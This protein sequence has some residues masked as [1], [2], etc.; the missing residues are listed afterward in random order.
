MKLEF[1]MKMNWY[2]PHSLIMGFIRMTSLLL[3]HKI[4]K[5][6]EISL[7]KKEETIVLF[8]YR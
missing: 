3:P 7:K 6:E 4:D 1:Y 8:K 5:M 2:K